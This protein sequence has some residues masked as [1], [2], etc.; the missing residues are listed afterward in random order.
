MPLGGEGAGGEA[1]GTGH[2]PQSPP[3]A[4]ASGL[5]SVWPAC[6]KYLDEATEVQGDGASPIPFSILNPHPRSLPLG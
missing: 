2:I 1:E 6:Q 4:P 5:R 3:L